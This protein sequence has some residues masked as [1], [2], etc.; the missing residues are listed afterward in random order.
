MNHKKQ[1]GAALIVSLIFLL[2][3][4]MIA[5]TSLNTS[6][7]EE[8]MA[9]NAQNTMRT[10]NAAESFIDKSIEDFTLLSSAVSSNSSATKTGSYG[11]DSSAVSTSVSVDLVR[12]TSEGYAGPL[13]GGMQWSS[14]S[15]SGTACFF[16]DATSTATLPTNTNITSSLTQGLWRQGAPGR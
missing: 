8:K 10:F 12:Q 9:V 5:V 15:T 7:L 14:G 13:C 16:M 1:Q 6:K 4:S 3:M 11:S 2:I